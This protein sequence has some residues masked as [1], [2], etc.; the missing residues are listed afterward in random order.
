MIV[1]LLHELLLEIL[2]I[3]GM[4]LRNEFLLESSWGSLLLSLTSILV[5]LILFFEL[6]VGALLLFYWICT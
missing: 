5:K 3:V 1:L 2:F 4:F 6:I